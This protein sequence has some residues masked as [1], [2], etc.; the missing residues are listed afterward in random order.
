MD[1]KEELVEGVDVG[2]AEEGGE[3]RVVGGVEFEVGG[4]EGI[5]TVDN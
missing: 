1:G 3:A 4:V 5:G 2:G